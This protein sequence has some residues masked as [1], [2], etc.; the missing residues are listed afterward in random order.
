MWQLFKYSPFLP[1]NDFNL[2]SHK[3]AALRPF[4]TRAKKA[5]FTF[6]SINHTDRGFINR[7][8]RQTTQKKTGLNEL[9]LEVGYQKWSV[10]SWLEWHRNSSGFSWNSWRLWRQPLRAQWLYN[11]NTP[12]SHV[13]ACTDKTAEHDTTNL[14]SLCI[15]CFF[16]WYDT[17]KTAE[18][19]SLLD[20]F[21]VWKVSQVPVNPLNSRES[22]HRLMYL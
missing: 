21:R 15:S 8:Q 22:L 16:L 13:Q 18:R 17:C 3:S 6:E 4:A 14:P 10:Y 2:L 12:Y 9:L 1:T 5:F 7:K 20:V 19:N 11:L